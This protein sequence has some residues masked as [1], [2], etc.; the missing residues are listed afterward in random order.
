MLLKNA[1]SQI[2]INL[3]EFFFFFFLTISL[4]SWLFLIRQQ[5]KL[6]LGSGIEPEL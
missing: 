3:G 1:P 6:C 4:E 5:K 2:G